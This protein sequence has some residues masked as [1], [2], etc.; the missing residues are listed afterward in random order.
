VVQPDMM[1][2]AIASLA[3][4]YTSSACEAEQVLPELALHLPAAPAHV[5]KKGRSNPIL[6]AILV[7]D[8]DS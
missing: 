7:T 8:R 6:V 4:Q 3:A 2:S 5:M 1:S